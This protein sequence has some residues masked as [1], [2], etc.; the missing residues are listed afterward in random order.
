[1]SFDFNEFERS[2]VIDLLNNFTIIDT[3]ENIAFGIAPRI[4]ASGRLDSVDAALNVL[5]SDNKQEIEMSIITLNDFNRVRQELC[6]NT[7]IEA[8][9][10]L[11]KSGNKDNSIILYNPK[12]HVGI[13]GIVASK[14]VEKYYKP[15]F[16][17]N[18]NPAKNEYRCSARSIEG[19]P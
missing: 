5:V 18:Y 8:E 7:F 13:V 16:L 9:E 2:S 10:M 12:W 3:S 15:V 19:V 11:K 6:E 1:M 14:L 17:M 4:N